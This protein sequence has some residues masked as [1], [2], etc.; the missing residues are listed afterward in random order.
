[1]GRGGLE[2]ALLALGLAVLPAGI[3]RVSDGDGGAMQ[4]QRRTHESGADDLHDR[5]LILGRRRPHVLCPP[6]REETH[7]CVSVPPTPALSSRWPSPTSR[8]HAA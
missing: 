6:L 2:L 1:M 5:G 8:R 7:R 4:G 3:G